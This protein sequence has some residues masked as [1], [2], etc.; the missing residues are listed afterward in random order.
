MLLQREMKRGKKLDLI[1]RYIEEQKY[2]YLER[3]GDL[4]NSFY[5]SF[6]ELCVESTVADAYEIFLETNTEDNFFRNNIRNLD[7]RAGQRFFKL[8]GIYHSIRMIR[9]KRGQLKWDEMEEALIHVYE[10]ND[11]EQKLADI[12]YQCACR[13]ETMFSDL[14]A[15][16]AARYLFFVKTLTPFSLAFIENFCYNSY[17]SFMASFTRYLSV[18]LRLKRAAN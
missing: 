9:K 8:M 11:M 12:L 2:E 17:S 1:Q 10:L 4:E 5:L 13:Y 16:T 18:N 3:T 14:F 15:K 7:E 6:Y